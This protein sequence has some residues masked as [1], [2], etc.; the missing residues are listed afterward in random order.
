MLP[1]A[2]PLRSPGLRNLKL[3]VELN[4]RSPLNLFLYEKIKLII[5]YAWL[6]QAWNK[7]KT[8]KYV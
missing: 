6:P 2:H 4:V 5:H 8:Q 1:S 7:L 3:Y